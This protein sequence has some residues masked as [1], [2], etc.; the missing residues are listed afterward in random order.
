MK[1]GL[2]GYGAMGRMVE[3]LALAAGDEIIL[4]VTSQDITDDLGAQLRGCEVVIDFSHADAVRANIAACLAANV[5]LVEGTTGWLK[6]LPE[7]RAQVQGA[8][9]A[10]VYGA[11]F[12]LG[13]NLFYRLTA[14]AAQL[15]AKVEGYEPFIEEA[16]HSRKKDAPSGTALKLR[17]IMRDALQRDFSVASTRAGHI[18][19]T[20]RVG[21][22]GAADQ[23]RLTHEARSREGFAAGALVAARWIR[24]RTGFYEFAEAMDEIL[25]MANGC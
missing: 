17:D 3:T 18:P 2:L 1:I 22:D 11:N 5:P 19:G 13:V 20:H 25:R 23:I 7:I 4:R 15:F 21:F 16:H 6:D 9:G 24:G 10:M 12:S 8:S 14:Y